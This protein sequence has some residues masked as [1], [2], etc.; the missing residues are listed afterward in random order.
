MRG[1]GGHPAPTVREKMWNLEAD[2][3]TRHTN[4]GGEAKLYILNVSCAASCHLTTEIGILTRL[5]MQS[6]GHFVV[7]SGWGGR[8][9]NCFFCASS[10][11][12]TSFR[13]LD[14]LEMPASS[15]KDRAFLGLCNLR[16][17]ARWYDPEPLGGLWPVTIVKTLA[18]GAMVKWA[19][20]ATVGGPKLKPARHHRGCEQFHTSCDSCSDGGCHLH[21]V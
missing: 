13:L 6:R 20:L 3:M 7:G 21:V 19:A 2:F 10:A 8:G 4:R 5:T 15:E 9:G 12:A 14:R 16:P 1:R 11:L 18:R 17:L